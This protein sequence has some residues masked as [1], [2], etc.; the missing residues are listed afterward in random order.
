MDL[1]DPECYAPEWFPMTHDLFGK[2]TYKDR[3]ESWAGSAPLPHFAAVGMPPEAPEMTEE[4]VRDLTA[5]MN[6]AMEEMRK[7]MVERFGERAAEALDAIDR[8]ADEE[9]RKHSE[10]PREPD[11]E[12]GARE[13]RRAERRAKRARLLAKGKFPV[14]VAGPERAE[15][16]PAQEAAFRF[17]VEN[18]PAV[19][20][21]VLAQVFDAYQT[22]YDDT[23]WR[24]L[25]GMKPVAAPAELAGLFAVTRLDI[26]R[27]SRGGF[28]YLIFLVESAWQDEHG[29]FVVYAPDARTARW[30][31]WEGLA[32]LIE[33]DEPEEDFVPTPHDELLEAIL[34]GEE[35]RAR[36]LVAAGADINALGEEEYPPLWI[37]VDQMEP[38]EVRRLLA[39]G[40]DPALANPDERTTPL[41]HAKRMYRDLGF[42]PSK[43][44]NPMMDGL[45]AMMRQTAGGQ[46][47]EVKSRLEEIIKLL[48]EAEGKKAV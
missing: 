8:A 4:E 24:Q 2:L 6:A 46:V 34:T 28:A 31:S 33:S 41:K 19:Y 16:T 30:T 14:R 11:P 43:N 40:A 25:A 12:E 1:S 47:D 37:A 9:A 48:E 27:E 17:L 3:D 36:E 38:D 26:T 20:D 22:A 21:A 18:E 23:Y 39:F 29:L 7:Q 42:A 44:H 45:L 13:A 35:G 10:G 15:P 32:E 5:N